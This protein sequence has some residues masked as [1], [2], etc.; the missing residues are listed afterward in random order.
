MILENPDSLRFVCLVHLITQYACTGWPIDPNPN[1][2]A[3]VDTNVRWEFA[4]LHGFVT[5]LPLPELACPLAIGF[6][7]LVD[8]EGLLPR[9]SEHALCCPLSNPI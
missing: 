9:N 7:L 3:M 2:C 6:M 1:R 8:C 4:K 5:R